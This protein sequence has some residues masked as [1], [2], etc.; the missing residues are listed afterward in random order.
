MELPSKEKIPENMNK[1]EINKTRFTQ[2]AEEMEGFEPSSLTSK[3][4]AEKT[5]DKTINIK[6]FHKN[7][8]KV[9]VMPYINEMANKF[10]FSS[11]KNI[12]GNEALKDPKFL[13]FILKK[14]AQI[15]EYI[16]EE[17]KNN[18]DFLLEAIKN[19]HS[20]LQYVSEELKNERS[21]I[22]ECVKVNGY[23]L[24]DTKE[25]FKNDKEIVLEA[26]KNK[27]ESLKYASEFLKADK[28]VVLEAVKNYGESIQYASE[29]LKTDKDV[30]LEAVKNNKMSKDYLNR[31]LKNFINKQE[32]EEDNFNL[33]LENFITTNNVSK[34]NKEDNIKNHAL[35][36]I[37]R[38]T[39]IKN[40]FYSE[41]VNEPT[42]AEAIK[43]PKFALHLVKQNGSYLYELPEDLRNNKEIVLEAVKNNGKALNYASENLKND[44]EVFYHAV[45]N[46]SNAIRYVNRDLQEF[47]I[48]K[49]VE[50]LIKPDINIKI[51][52]VLDK[53]R[54]FFKSPENTN[55]NKIG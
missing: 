42:I 26:V 49:G 2:I 13:F 32:R 17:L 15:F 28:D 39:Q 18:K 27:G 34:E 45:K 35:F 55:K 47:A 3:F 25:K 24:F 22:L 12:N 1:I 11:G 8:N 14:D 6:D 44:K 54:S 48:N 9:R 36:P 21:F 20:V 41:N 16:Q 31:D 52:G 23:A 19:N 4:L 40:E 53:V 29:F 38:I 37:V 30:V 43:D 51:E 10:Y 33:I 50:N 5:F 46:D 7:I